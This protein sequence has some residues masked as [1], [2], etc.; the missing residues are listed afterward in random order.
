MFKIENGREHFWQWDT[1][2]RLI[3]G[4]SIPEVH[5]S[6][7]T[8]DSSL[9]KKTYQENGITY[10]DV[11][12]VIL[13]KDWRIHVY[14]FDET[15][16]KYEEFFDVR[17]RARPDD[18]VYTDEDKKTWEELTARIDEIE[19]NGI[20]Q[21]KIE[22]AVNKYL[23][24]NPIETGATAEQAAQIEANK[25]A[26]AALEGSAASKEY[27]D[28]AVS[29]IDL[30]EYAKKTEIPTN[31]S[32]LT[33][34]AGYLTQHQSLAEYAKKSEIPSLEGYAKTSD[35]PTNVS[36]LTNDAGYL[37]QHQSLAEYAK[38]SEIPSLDG[39]A[40][41]SQIPDVSNFATKSEIPDVSSYQTAEQVN[42]LID[43]KL[44]PSG[45]EVSY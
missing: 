7:R 44:P 17:G 38:K 2:Q 21:E 1:N 5:F 30:S 18:Y 25:T 23:D 42:A 14:A 43:A 10:V 8:S 36:S 28:S 3:V 12:N 33:N 37:T 9:V 34:D 32:S 11:P 19:K 4:D 15:Y 40:K 27:V 6:N 35:I 26:I 29:S 31:V 41:I 16:T 45:E 20:S 13:Q 22:Q 24:A 39:Y